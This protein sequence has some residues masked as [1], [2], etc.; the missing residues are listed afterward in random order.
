[1]RLR[2]VPVQLPTD[3]QHLQLETRQYELFNR[4]LGQGIPRRKLYLGAATSGVWFLIMLIVGVDPLSSLGPVLYIVPPFALVFLG[5]KVGD[6]GRMAY[7]RWYDAILA[8]RPSRR[9]PQRNPLLPAHTAH[10]FHVEECLVELHPHPDGP[11]E[12]LLGRNHARPR[13]RNH[14]T[15]HATTPSTSHAIPEVVRRPAHGAPHRGR[16]SD[17]VPRRE[18]HR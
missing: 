18:A 3:T 8:R 17:P 6:D 4:P 7:L 13:D 2:T 12:P 1:M 11:H 15:P 9:R 16:T 10:T 5:T 14:A